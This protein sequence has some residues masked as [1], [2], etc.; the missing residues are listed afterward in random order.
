MT[1]QHAKQRLVIENDLTEIAGVIAAFEGFAQACAVPPDTAAR[2][3]VIFDELLSNIIRYGYPDQ[4]RH[5]IG[6]CMQRQGERLSVTI[7]DD[8]IPFDPLSTAPPNTELPV[9]EREVGGLGI[10][11]VR[12]LVHDAHYRREDGRNI[13]TLMQKLD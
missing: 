13:I 4:E 3:N 5:E 11:L 12:N 9:R 8:G 10:H 7:T 6:I 1:E 2:F